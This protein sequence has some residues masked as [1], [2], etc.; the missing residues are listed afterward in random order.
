MA[1]ELRVLV[2]TSEGAPIPNAVVTVY[3]LSGDHQ[4]TPSS[5]PLVVA[6]KG[7]A[8][9]PYVLVAPVGSLVTFPNRDTVRHHVYSFSPAHRF[10][11]KLYG[12]EEH[13]VERFDKVGVVAMGCNIHDAM[14]AYID[15]VDTRFAAKTDGQG[16]AL[17]SD[18]PPG[19]ATM[20][21]WHPNAKLAGGTLTKSLTLD[22]NSPQT[23]IA[24]DLRPPPPGKQNH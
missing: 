6:Q 22:A 5:E 15:V 8:F 24:L 18:L 19:A 7:I 11:L 21:V 12:R 13:R 17:I 1:A 23:L 4:P 14:A 3:P 9:D 2:R 16:Q 20:K 10:E